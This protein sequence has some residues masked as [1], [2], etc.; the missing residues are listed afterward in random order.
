MREFGHQTHGLD[1]AVKR[2]EVV[3]RFQV[4]KVT[5]DQR[6]TEFITVDTQ[7]A[8]NAMEVDLPVSIVQ[9]ARCI[10]DMQ[11]RDAARIEAGAQCLAIG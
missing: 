8:T 3:G 11:I 2:C 7:Y 9:C 5:I 4:V 10:F 6:H 1:T